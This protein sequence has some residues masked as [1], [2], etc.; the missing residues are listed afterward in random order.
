MTLETCFYLLPELRRKGFVFYFDTSPTVYDGA[1]IR[2]V[3][4]EKE[5]CPITAL[6]FFLTD[7]RYFQTDDYV[8]AAAT[9]H[10]SKEVAKFLVVAADDRERTECHRSR[11]LVACGLEEHEVHYLRNDLTPI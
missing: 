2:V 4:E 5:F 9:V 7:G 8:Q 3:F 1:R 11:F 6:V 10:I